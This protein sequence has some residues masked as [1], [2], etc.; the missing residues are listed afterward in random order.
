MNIKLNK[1]QK[2]KIKD[3]YDLYVVM[4][5]ILLRQQKIDRNREHVWAVGLATDNSILHI[6]LVSMGTINKSLVEPMEVFSFALQK[7]AVKLIL[8]HNHPSGSLEPSESDI[9]I[10]DRLVQTGVIV[11]LPLVD[12]LIITELSFYSFEQSGLMSRIR[13]SRKYVPGYV[14]VDEHVKAK[15]VGMAR[16]MKSNG[17]PTEKIMKYTGLSEQEIGEID[18]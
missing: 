5:Q 8:V 15:A 4:Q 17:E 11:N 1:D 12:H 7:R 2:I 13:K 9:D 6:E 18:I 14:I 16:A 10:T 3:G